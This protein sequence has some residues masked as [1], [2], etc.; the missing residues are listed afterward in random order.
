M[1]LLLKSEQVANEAN[2]EADLVDVGG[3]AASSIE[4]HPVIARL[5]RLNKLTQKLEDRVE[6]KVKTLPE[7]MDN[8]VKAC[9]LMD[10]EGG[11]HD[12]DAS[13][14][15]N[16]VSEAEEEVVVVK[17]KTTSGKQAKTHSTEVSDPSSS[18]EESEDDIAIS[19]MNDAR[20]GLRPQ[21]LEADSGSTKKR[22]RRAVPLDYGDDEED[23]GLTTKAAQSLA[24]TLNA[25]E[26]RSATRSRK[27]RSACETETLDEQH[28]DDA[29][30]RGLEM[31]EAELGRFDSDHEGE[32]VGE[33][34]GKLDDDPDEDDFYKSM[35]ERSN[36]KKQKKTAKY[37]VAPKYPGMDQEVRGTYMLDN[38]IFTI[39]AYMRG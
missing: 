31:M 20:F 24:S 5:Q 19:V 36:A 2:A 27:K 10:K 25:I 18:N 22:S 12:S 33:M 16:E 6:S 21:E 37:A 14:Q 7:Q 11:E 29:L 4:S 35:T 39:C 38:L 28:D 13:S 15:Q 9:D 23:I 30:C 8:L 32:A 1:Y 34:N 3:N 17:E 26:Q